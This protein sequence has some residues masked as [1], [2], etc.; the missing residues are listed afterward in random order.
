[1][2]GYGYGIWLVLNNDF[3]KN[4]VLKYNEIPHTRHVTIMCNMSYNDALNCYNELVQKFGLN[5]LVSISKVQDFYG[6]YSSN[7]PYSKAFGWNVTYTD[8]NKIIK[9]VQKYK[10]TASL[11]PHL[12]AAYGKLLSSEIIDDISKSE[13]TH[14]PINAYISL[15][16]I[17]Y[18]QSHQWE[19]M[20]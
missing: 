19:I 4:T 10:G 17:T 9:Y 8:Y 12:T 6:Q 7:D 13:S 14:E 5:H 11:N 18:E 16:N 1:M 15:A 2:V 3:G 20:R